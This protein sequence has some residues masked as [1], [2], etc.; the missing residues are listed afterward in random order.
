MLS[1]VNSIRQSAPYMCFGAAAVLIPA[2]FWYYFF[3]AP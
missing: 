2:G 1:F 3:R